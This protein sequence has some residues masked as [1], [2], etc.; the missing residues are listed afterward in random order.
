[1]GAI[2]KIKALLDKPD[3]YRNA[4]SD[5]RE[6]QL[7]AARERFAERRSKIKVLDRR[8]REAGIDEIRSFS[9]LVPLLFSHTNY[10]GYP[11]S[12]M[13]N[14]QWSNMNRWLETMSSVPVTGMDIG[15]I[16]DADDWLARLEAAGHYVFA[17]SGT[18]GKCSFLDQ[19]AEDRDFSYKGFSTA[20]T[21]AWKPHVPAN[22]H[23]VYAFMSPKGTHRY[24][25]VGAQ[26]QKDNV[27]AP[28]EL[29]HLS[30]EPMLSSP[31][32]RAGMLRRR[33]AAGTAL[34][35]E[36]AAFDAENAAQAKKMQT[37]MEEY[38]DEI[39]ENLHKPISFSLQ[40][41][42][43][44][45]VAEGLRAR[46]VKD[47]DVHPDTI[48]QMG[49]GVKGV[50]L[51]DDFRERVYSFFRLP[52]DHYPTCY[53]MVEMTGMC[54]YKHELGGYAFPPWQIPL[55]LD[56]SGEQLLN[57]ADEKGIVEGRMAV[58]DLLAEARWGGVISGDKVTVEFSPGDGLSGPLV[59]SIARYAELEE[60]EDKLSCAGTIDAYV[61][62]E[63]KL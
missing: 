36:V 44:F 31:G 32:I 51:P 43:A 19:N 61:R 38:L 54:P 5:L 57:P 53:G 42:Q 50:K 48:V 4:P 25:W 47:G 35:D 16:K 2:Q 41:P 26:F 1:M 45:Q 55:I 12:F 13:D 29:L 17:S 30:E 46:G 14:A 8:A 9:D 59:R 34:P 15:D 20:F 27:A 23:I 10:K 62:G 39:R 28:G 33:L 18:S 7:E 3:P 40:W 49:G 37:R 52:K 56:K 22:R 58:F 24:S 6:L 63:L 21:E 60:S 11:D